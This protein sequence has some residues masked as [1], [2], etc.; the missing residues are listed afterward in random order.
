MLCCVGCLFSYSTDVYGMETE[1]IEVTQEIKDGITAY[2]ETENGEIQPLDCDIS[3]V[4]HTLSTRASGDMYTLEVKSSE[5]KDSSDSI[6]QSGIAL[7]GRITWIDHLGL[8]NELVSYYGLYSNPSQIAFAKYDVG[9]SNSTK[10]SITIDNITNKSSF[11]YTDPCHNKGVSFFLYMYMRTNDNHIVR[12]T[13]R[14]SM[15]D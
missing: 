8:T 13:V 9:I 7:T 1:K 4:K 6:A 5:Q 14:T 2:I 3:L 10:H 12:M 15:L 11:Y